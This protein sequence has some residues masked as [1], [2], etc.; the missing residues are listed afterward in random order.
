LRL[1]DI[2]P[3]STIPNRQLGTY[4]GAP[5]TSDKSLIKPCFS[6]DGKYIASGAGDR[7][8]VI[9]DRDSA[10]ILY[11]LPGHKGT[12]TQVAWNSKEPISMCQLNIFATI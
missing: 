9:W 1:W 8:V 6:A 4:N 12:V 3:F 5:H 11:K 10:E 7:T 2:R